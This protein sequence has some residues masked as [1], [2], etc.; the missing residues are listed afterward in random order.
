[1][2]TNILNSIA[3]LNSGVKGGVVS[4]NVRFSVSTFS[5]LLLMQ[6]HGFIRN[7]RCIR[8]H[9]KSKNKILQVF[10]TY[11][12]SQ[13]LLFGIKSGS[14]PTR[15]FFVSAQDLYSCFKF[16]CVLL[17]HTHLGILTHT[18]ALILGI[19]GEIIC[20]LYV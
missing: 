15:R 10:F 5:F 9:R 17:L 6:K 12:H 4:S 16:H 20:F 14:R 1:M 19:G 7:L 11:V 8:L 13:A 2:H 3:T 18:E